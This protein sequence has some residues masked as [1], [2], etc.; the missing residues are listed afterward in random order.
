[1]DGE[2]ID[3]LLALFDQR[4]AEYLEGQVLGDAAD[5]FKCL[6]D[7]HRADRDRRVADDPFADVVDVA[8][9]RE[10]HHRVGA[11][12]D[13]PHHLVDLFP[14]GGGDSGISDVG[15]DLHQEIA[16]DDHR[17]AFGVIDVGGDDRATARDFATHKLRCNDGRN[18]RAEAFPVG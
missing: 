2:I 12:A 1:M 16:T 13:R 9:G 17:L 14:D 11:P 3:A 5:L 8:P 18:F 10:V 15:V 7:R 6:I 4:V